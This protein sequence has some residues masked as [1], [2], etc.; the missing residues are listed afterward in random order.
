MPVRSCTVTHLELAFQHH[1]L[2]EEM[3]EFSQDFTGRS[4]IKLSKD[5]T[6]SAAA[7]TV[8]SPGLSYI[9]ATST[10]HSQRM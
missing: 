8:V 4:T 7:S 10:G 5:C 3:I 2:G 6:T 1:V 9:G